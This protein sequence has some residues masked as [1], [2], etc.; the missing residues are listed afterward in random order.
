[1]PKPFSALIHHQTVPCENSFPSLTFI[2]PTLSACTMSYTHVTVETEH[3]DSTD[4]DVP[5]FYNLM[6]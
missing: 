3:L 1:M 5:P 6:I 4:N 2:F